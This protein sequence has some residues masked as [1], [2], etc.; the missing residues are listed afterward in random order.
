MRLHD[1]APR[2][3]GRST[4][5]R[6]QVAG[7]PEG[8]RRAPFTKWG[9][10]LAGRAPPLHGGGQGFESPQLHHQ[11]QTGTIRC[12]GQEGAKSLASSRELPRDYSHRTD[13]VSV[14]RDSARGLAAQ[15][16]R[17]TVDARA[18]NFSPST[19]K[20][21]DLG[22]RLFHEFMGGVADVRRA[23]RRLTGIVVVL[24]GVL[25][26][27][28]REERIDAVSHPGYTFIMQ[29]LNTETASPDL[30]LQCAAMLMEVVPAVMRRIRTEMRSQRM[31]SLSVPQFR[32][33]I[34]LRRNEGA[35][36]SDVAD[37]LGIM[38]PSMSKAIDALVGRGLVIRRV[39]PSDRRYA[40]LRLSA[41]GQ[42]ELRR[43]RSITEANLALALSAL[44]PAQQAEVV[45][46][47]RAMGQVFAPEGLASTTKDT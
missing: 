25:L 37:Q 12:T 47:L 24:I 21:M 14:A 45:Q 18:Q 2:L 35:S 31:P 17:Y 16:A 11:A 5:V 6:I 19:V 13:D 27:P 33:L 4:D 46:G 39:S 7:S 3:T 10:S 20:K 28:Q 8:G 22:L 29:P 43:A 34:Y 42:T 32:A 41:R 1:A 9:C 44:S 23:A 36:L 15:L 26:R 40:S 38:L 30:K